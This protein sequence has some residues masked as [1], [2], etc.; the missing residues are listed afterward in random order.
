M[1]GSHIVPAAEVILD[2]CYSGAE[3]NRSDLPAMVTAASAHDEQ[4]LN[5]Y[6]LRA[7]TRAAE[8]LA[9]ALFTLLSMGEDDR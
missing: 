7:G 9:D 3:R 2:Q 8:I 5:T 6:R 4:T 1:A